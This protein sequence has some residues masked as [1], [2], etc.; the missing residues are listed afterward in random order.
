MPKL[1]DALR[2]RL[3][4]SQ[5][6]TPPTPIHAAYRGS[7]PLHQ[8]L[9]QRTLHRMNEDIG[10]WR[11][12]LRHAESREHPQRR[13]LARVYQEIRL[14]AHL[15]ALIRNRQEA[16]L[17][18]DF[19]LLSSRGRED[20]LAKKWLNQPWLEDAIRAILESRLEGHVLIELGPLEQGKL[21]GVYKFPMQYVEPISGNLLADGHLAGRQIPYRGVEQWQTQLIEVGQP[22]D[23]GLLYKAA[24]H[25]LWKRAATK[26]WAEYCQLFGMPVAIAKTEALDPD[27]KQALSD[28]LSDM[29]A[30]YHIVMD[31]QEELDF[32]ES[33][34]SDGSPV[35][36]KLVE[37]CNTELSKLI[38]GQTMTTDSGS[39]R[40]QAEVHLAMQEQLV[41]ADLR[42]V[43]RVLN[44][45]LL[46]RLSQ[47]GAPLARL[48]FRFSRYEQ[49]SPADLLKLAERY[50]IDPQYLSHR[51][52][53]PL[54]AAGLPAS[55]AAQA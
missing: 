2:G 8:Q 40:S 29:R 7:S 31:K 18:Q 17:A 14:D 9:M 27:R 47:L 52:G 22:E 4:S 11:S 34:R 13:E 46:P 30:A 16:V 32:V 49:L 5:A 20:A 36:D 1:I 44:S 24:P 38:L 39:S 12:A 55:E 43:E 19:S 54:L 53:L 25:V 23:L 50:P 3:R 15:S 37:R 45:E 42:F 6:P 48:Q 28:M 41:Q 35:Y 51:F 33:A 21:S 26:F 10:S